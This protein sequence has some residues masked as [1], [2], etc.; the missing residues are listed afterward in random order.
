MAWERWV[1][2]DEDVSGADVSSVADAASADR[3]PAE[4][5]TTVP[6]LKRIESNS[7]GKI[8]KTVLTLSENRGG[9]G[10]FYAGLAA[11]QK[12]MDANWIWVEDD[13]AF[14]EPDAF[15]T[16]D[17]FVKMHRSMMRKCSAFCGMC[18]DDTGGTI[19]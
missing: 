5:F 6:S 13:D 3:N 14:P 8:R 9:S 19:L 18:V 17:R 10:G 16:A 7:S 15:S 4:L 11:A 1:V 2:S 12:R